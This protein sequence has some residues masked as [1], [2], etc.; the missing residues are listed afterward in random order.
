[1]GYSTYCSDW[2]V[3][4]AGH[5]GDHK[6][7]PDQLAE[8]VERI[9]AH[10]DRTLKHGRTNTITYCAEPDGISA[11]YCE[12]GTLLAAS[13]SI[14]AP[15]APDEPQ[16][17]LR[18]RCPACGHHNEDHGCTRTGCEC[19]AGFALAAQVPAQEERMDVERWADELSLV[20]AKA[21]FGPSVDMGGRH[22]PKPSEVTAARR[23]MEGVAANP[24]ADPE[25]GA[26]EYEK[27]RRALGDESKEGAG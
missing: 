17:G 7:R 27:V 13:D 21:R 22:N 18:E 15:D 14:F 24:S 6:F 10:H 20:I 9:R 2:C 11:T 4:A 19:H 3:F 26:R 1:M 5:T 12:V 16:A 25:Y 23:F 8:A